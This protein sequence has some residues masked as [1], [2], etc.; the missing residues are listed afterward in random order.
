[1]LA[2]G[3][4]PAVVQGGNGGLAATGALGRLRPPA[5]LANAQP[6]GLLSLLKALWSNPL[7]AWTQEH[8]QRPVVVSKLAFGEVAVVSDPAAIHHVLVRNVD[9]YK[10]DAF[11]RRMLAIL[12]NG[13]LAAEG[14]QWRT[15]RRTFAPIFS[16]KTVMNFAPAMKDAV[17]A[18]VERWRGHR[19]GDVLDVAAEVTDLTLD[20]LVRTIFSDGLG[21]DATQ[22]RHAMRIYFDRIGR[23]DPLD[24]LGI[25]NFVPRLGRL[26]VRPAVQLFDAAV[27]EIIAARRRRLAAD[28]HSVPRD[29]LTL[30]LEA[31]D[32]ETGRGI[33]EA[34]VRANIVTFMAA[35]HETTAN[36]IA[37]TLYLLSQSGEWRDRVRA[38]AERELDGAA[39][40]V[41][42]RL[43]ETR[44]VV[45]EALRLYPPLAAISRAAIGP[46]ELAGER[47]RAGA[48][49]VIAPY[50]LHRHRRLWQHPDEFDP[51][52]FLPAER[53]SIERHAYLPFGA[54]AR[55]CIGL[56]FA[57][58][59]AMLA[60]A[61]ITANFEL[62]P[63][64]GHEVWP[65]HRVT[66]RPRGGLP[67]V[68]RRR[69][70]AEPA[71]VSPSRAV[72]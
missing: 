32:P 29:I 55:G 37:W 44:A 1:M 60:V 24:V 53:K 68:L 57:L 3:T 42:E 11:Q 23:I 5:P 2:A 66:L 6:L 28:P 7:E 41:T 62:S 52:R 25:P 69:A 36:A 4:D 33:S 67:M 18:L 27:D 21:R 49:V 70:V 15:Q 47:I 35:G 63:V 61:S 40:D 26:S 45:E 51:S 50:V 16:P 20:V 12:A 65:V 64:A 72:A 8:F 14:E 13:L 46:D 31:Q 56:V 43:I 71:E 38:E 34:E 59:E 30:L 19:D 39:A 54:G 10:K 17:E 58:Q 9:N 48:M 22:V